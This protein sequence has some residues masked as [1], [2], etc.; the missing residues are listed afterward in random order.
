MPHFFSPELLV[1]SFAVFL[2]SFMQSI[3]GFGM[4]IIATPLLIVT[5][6]PK[7]VVIVLVFLSLC[8]NIVF[9]LY[10]LREANLKMVAYLAL[11]AF[12][13]QPLGLA[14][15]GSV[16][17][18]T[19]KLIVSFCILL[20]LILMKCLHVRIPESNRNSAVT[21][22]FSGVLITT[23][24]MSGPPLVM[25]LAS[26]RQTPAVTRATC[27]LYFLIVNTTSLLGFW[28]AGK[29][30]HTAMTTGLSLL[31]GLAVG[32]LVGNLVFKYVS[33]K[34]FHQLLLGMLLATC[35]YTFYTVFF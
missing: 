12:L 5:Y 15:Y 2:A 3:T 29:D 19:L 31:P 21:G 20:F 8:S 14:I 27:V 11:G 6:E 4:A 33:A 34:L 22:F 23:T 28:L 24:G 17:N 7:F 35:L 13:G 30:L 16:S 26:T 32:L 10:L 9:S 18:D 1:P 25:Y